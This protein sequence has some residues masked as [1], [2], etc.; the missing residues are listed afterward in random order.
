MGSAHWGNLWPLSLSPRDKLPSWRLTLYKEKKMVCQKLNHFLDSCVSSPLCSSPCIPT[1]LSAP[2]CGC[3]SATCTIAKD[4]HMAK[5]PFCWGRCCHKAC[6]YSASHE[7]Y[8]LTASHTHWIVLCILGTEWK[9]WQATV[10]A[11]ARVFPVP[12]QAFKH[13][14]ESAFNL[15]AIQINLLPMEMN[16]QNDK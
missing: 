10:L 7:H 12:E 8:P 4:E 2:L 1:D 6:G 13:I 15:L 3:L 11:A 14:Q 5:K 9:K 16:K